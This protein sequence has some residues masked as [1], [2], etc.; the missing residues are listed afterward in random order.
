MTLWLVA[1]IPTFFPCR[2]S[3]QIMRAP[4]KCLSRSRRPLDREHRIIQQCPDALRGVHRGFI[5]EDEYIR[6]QLDAG[7]GVTRGLVPRGMVRESRHHCH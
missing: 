3:S 2:T 5:G 7:Y 1:V 4:R 6:S